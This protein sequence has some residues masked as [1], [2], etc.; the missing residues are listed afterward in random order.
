MAKTRQFTIAV[1]NRSGAVAE[2]ARALGSAKVNILALL[3]TAQGTSGTVQLIVDDT[4]RAKRALGAANL[5][6]KE[7]V[8]EEIELPNRPGALAQFLE[9]VAR[10][11]INLS[12]VWATTSKSARKATVTYIAEA[13]KEE[14]V[15]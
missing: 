8:A 14:F 7:N 9:K 3:G 2:I 6:Y 5:S 10:K 4:K 12:S 11:D 1:E 15:G 13:E